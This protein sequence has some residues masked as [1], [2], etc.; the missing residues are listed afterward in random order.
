MVGR[1]QE[2]IDMSKKESVEL[3]FK[4]MGSWQDKMSKDEGQ[5]AYGYVDLE[6]FKPNA[7][8][9]PYEVAA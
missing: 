7:Y 9:K 2:P 4:S 6:G 1:D 3:F 5:Y 8:G